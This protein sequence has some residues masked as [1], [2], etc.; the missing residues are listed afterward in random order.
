MVGIF[1]G[2]DDNRSLGKGE[3]GAVAAVPIFIEFM[4]EALKG[5]PVMDFTA[6]PGTEFAQV[7]PNREAFR[8]GTEPAPSGR[9][10]SAP[11]QADGAP[12]QSAGAPPGPRRPAEPPPPDRQADEPKQAR[13]AERIVL[14]AGAA[15]LPRLRSRSDFHESGYRSG[16]GR[17]RAVDRTAQEASLT[18]SRP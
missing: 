8:P 17:H 4:Q 14:S 13:R 5:M 12:T 10:R 1:V 16:R 2:F 3:T 6:P 7:G 15:Y 11:G 9:R 18:G